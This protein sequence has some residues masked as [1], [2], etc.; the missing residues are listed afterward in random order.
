MENE[1]LKRGPGRPSKYLKTE[2][3]IHEF[4]K[5]IVDG[6]PRRDFCGYSN[7]RWNFSRAH[8]YLLKKEYANDLIDL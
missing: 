6:R 8:F 1:T 3:E 4:R 2:H 7:S 5:M